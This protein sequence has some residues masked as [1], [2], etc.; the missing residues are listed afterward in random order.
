MSDEQINQLSNNLPKEMSAQ[1]L[2]EDSERAFSKVAYSD[3]KRVAGS[4]VE[5]AATFV[6]LNTMSGAKLCPACNKYVSLMSKCT[7]K[8]G[9]YHL[10]LCT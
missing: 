2:K 7:V 4:D 5:K 9:I 6:A 1:E 3:A 10:N 8:H